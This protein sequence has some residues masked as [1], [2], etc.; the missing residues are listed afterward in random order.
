MS[1]EQARG[2][3]TDERTDIYSLGIVL[4][5]LLTGHV[6][7]DGETTMA[8][9]LKQVTEPPPPVPDLSP[10]LQSVLNRALAKKPD[11]RFQTPNELADAFNAAIEEATA[12]DT[13]MESEPKITTHITTVGYRVKPRRRWV[14][15][16]L[17]VV[18][19]A[20]F[21]GFFL[22]RETFIPPTPTQTGFP[23]QSLAATKVIANTPTPI[24]IPAGV[25]HFQDSAAIL[26]QVSLSALE[27][28][29]PPDGSHYEVW[30]SGGGTWQSLGI[31]L[32]DA[33]GKGELVSK[34]ITG[35][36]LL[37]SYDQVYVTIELNSDIDANP[38]S[39][40]AY[41]SHLPAE[42]LTHLRHLLVSSAETPNG[43][44]FVHGLSVD[45]GLI[46]QTARAMQS[47]Y[48]KGNVTAAR[49]SAEAVLNLL[50][51]DESEDYK[52]WNGD[53]Q[54]ADPSDGFGL[55][56]N[57]TK[58]GYLQA[59]LSHT[60]LAVISAGA[61]QNIIKHG[62]EVKT[63]AQNL[64]LWTS[65]LRDLVLT[66]VTSPSGTDLSQPILDSVKLA[67]Q[68]LNGEDA[69]N[70]KS[71]DAVAGECGMSSMYGYT[72]SM[73]DM[74]L[75]PFIPTTV[76]VTAETTTPTL[77]AAP[78][79]V[80]T[81]KPRNTTAPSNPTKKPPGKPPTKTPRKP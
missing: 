49:Q 63:C 77:T 8:I 7:F 31:L 27:M 56:S 66:I 43:A 80:N 42:G 10:G 11:D 64:S 48:Q 74:A 24:P 14:T 65:Q 33:N 78:P 18:S 44:A 41:S 30:L 53:G 76:T 29:V 67:D 12:S 35:A 4:Y 28:V 6:P 21:S 60:E 36:N 57:G 1:P 2:E 34:D 71:I 25:L 51:G 59:V 68:L 81:P 22:F 20:L 17:A 75:L 50:A 58:P 46:D 62:E 19:V 72:Y 45:I 23:T 55:L 54:V 5:E 26:D 61:T 70:N 40:I 16:L 38:S 39:L 52:D 69:D 32:L 9:I 13:F 37:S 47:A 3:P 73:A 15:A 79:G